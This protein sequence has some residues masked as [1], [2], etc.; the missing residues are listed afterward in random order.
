MKCERVRDLVSDA[1]DGVLG[2]HIVDR[3]HQHLDSCPPCQSYY[4]ELKESL[5][6]LEE[7]PVL[8]VDDSFDRAVWAR[9]RT[10]EQPRSIGDILRER[11]EMLRVR[12][13]FGTGLWRW[14][15]VGVAALVLLGLAV[16]SDPSR[17]PQGGESRLADL[18][19]V[20]DPVQ[21]SQPGSS[22]P[23]SEDPSGLQEDAGNV[24][25]SSFEEEEFPSAMPQAVEAFLQTG[26]DLRFKNSD[27]YEHSNYSYPLRRIPDPTQGRAAGFSLRRGDPVRTGTAVG[28]TVPAQSESGVTVLAF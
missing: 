26:R 13:S 9:I 25:V 18:S 11:A 1:L 5:L 10:E 22:T 19:P 28:A 24:I 27:T 2:D 20:N 12:F 7:L 23:R 4:T 21:E 3:F 14:S 15:P 8:E 16:S 6:L 17:L